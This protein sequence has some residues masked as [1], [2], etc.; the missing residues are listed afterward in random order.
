MNDTTNPPAAAAP[1]PVAGIA[2]TAIVLVLI[3]AWIV[4]G[5][6][7]DVVTTLAEVAI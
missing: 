6:D 1:G 3:V 5:L 4:L 2:I 7:Y